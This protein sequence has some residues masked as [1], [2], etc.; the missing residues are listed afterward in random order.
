MKPKNAIISCCLTRG[1]LLFDGK[2]SDF[3][4]GKGNFEEK[5]ISILGGA[6]EKESKLAAIMPLLKNALQQ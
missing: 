4:E 1:K 2:P 5:F 3:A 6:P